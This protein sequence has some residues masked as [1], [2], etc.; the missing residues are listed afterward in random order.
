MCRA[1][2][3]QDLV[4][5]LLHYDPDAYRLEHAIRDGRAEVVAVEALTHGII[6]KLLH[7]PQIALKEAAGSPRGDRLVAALRAKVYDGVS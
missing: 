6:G 1:M 2:P 3:E 5:E 7:D 4:V